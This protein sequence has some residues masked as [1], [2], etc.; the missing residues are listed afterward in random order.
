MPGLQR[1]RTLMTPDAVQSPL[2][3]FTGI[4]VVQVGPGSATCS[5]P[6][7]TL[8]LDPLQWV[9]LFML[10]EATA[11]MAGRAGAGPHHDVRCAALSTHHQ[12]VAHLDAE[13][14]IARATT[15]HSGRTYSLVEVA[16][17]DAVGR[18]VARAMASLVGTVA[19]DGDQLDAPE[20]AWPTPDPWQRTFPSRPVNEALDAYGGPAQ[21]DTNLELLL[22]PLHA[23][24]GLR[25]VETLPGRHA[26]SLPTS[27][28]LLDR[29][30]RISGGVV[31]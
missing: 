15:V 30:D 31:V 7:S 10:A 3:R 16:V 26:T 21:P 25:V 1:V 20:P 13:R 6:A 8:L 19:I 9:D 23:Q 4:R 5:V 29:A 18:P 14:L 24:L 17:E 28:W 22:A 12:R 2:F 27:R 11:T